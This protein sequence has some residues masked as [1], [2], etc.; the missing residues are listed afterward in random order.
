VLPV[1]LVDGEIVALNAHG[2]TDFAA[3]Q[4]ALSDDAT[5]N[6]VYFVFD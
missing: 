2:L 5:E 1:A 3:L 6:L 4:A